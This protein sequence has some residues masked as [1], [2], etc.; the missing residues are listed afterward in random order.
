MAG[1]TLVTLEASTSTQV[2]NMP[3][4]YTSFSNSTV[5]AWNLDASDSW[6]V[7][8]WIYKVSGSSGGGDIFYQ[9]PS[10]NPFANTHYA[11]IGYNNP[12][13]SIT[14]RVGD[15]TSLVLSHDEPSTAGQWVH[16]ALCYDSVANLITAY[17]DGVQVAQEP[18]TMTQVMDYAE[19]GDF[20]NNTVELGQL[21]VWSGHCL[22][23]GELAAEM[24][25]WNPQT[26][27]SDV[28]AWLQLE[29]A[30][31]AADSSGNGH[32]LANSGAEGLLTVPGAANPVTLEGTATLA[33]GSLLQLSAAL[34]VVGSV[35][36]LSAGQL[37]AVVNLTLNATVNLTSGSHLQP[38]GNRA[39][40]LIWRADSE[41]SNAM[42]HSPWISNARPN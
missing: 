1:L 21:K 9:H 28:Y 42:R 34:G 3:R 37:S 6:S 41:D 16:A 8:G 18:I 39:L 23:V 26:A 40:P 22:T 19:I 7:C 29:N 31:P 24:A 30:D 12:G 13:L 20:G 11:Y 10:D 25:F 27:L 14:F 5:D 2:G 17:V 15:G 32:T 33:S 36:L 35:T 38:A 4:R